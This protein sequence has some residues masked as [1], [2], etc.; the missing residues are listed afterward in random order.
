MEAVVKGKGEAVSPMRAG[1]T[2][3]VQ[4][5]HVIDLCATQARRNYSEGRL[6]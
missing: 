2:G 6:G 3:Y 1:T 4:V 5:R